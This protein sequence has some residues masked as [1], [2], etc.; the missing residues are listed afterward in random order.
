[1]TGPALA[2]TRPDGSRKYRHPLT[3]EEVPSV[4]TVIKNAFPKP[5]LVGWAAR[6]AAEYAVSHWRELEPLTVQEKVDRI[7]Y[8]HEK[9]R[10]EASAKGN[11]VHETIDAWSKGEALAI[12]KGTDSFVNQYTDFVITRRPKFIENEVTLWSRTYGYAG[13][14]DWIAE[15]DGTIYLGD[16]KT[17]KGVYAEAALQLSAL[18]GCDFI[19]REDGSEEEIPALQ[20]LAALHVRPRSWKFITVA[21]REECFSAFLAARELMTWSEKVA[22]YVL[23]R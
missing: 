2:I 18:A 12:Y 21:R 13:T 10:D 4:T 7:R 23:G 16:N 5:A 8:A 3:G 1:M 20:E 6:M 17:G 19:I 9:V 14:A 22:P 11:A 15:I